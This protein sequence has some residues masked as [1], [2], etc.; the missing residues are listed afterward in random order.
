LR[1]AAMGSLTL[2]GLL[3]V[4]AC[5]LN[6]EESNGNFENTSASCNAEAKVLDQAKTL[7][8]LKSVAAERRISADT[9]EILSCLAYLESSY[10]TK[11]VSNPN[12]NGTIDRGLFQINS[13]HI[14]TTC[15]YDQADLLDPIKN[16]DCA[17]RVYS[18]SIKGLGAWSS[19]GKRNLRIKAIQDGE[20]SNDD[21]AFVSACLTNGASIQDLVALQTDWSLIAPPNPVTSD[22]PTPSRF[23][24]LRALPA[25]TEPQVST[26]QYFIDDQP[27]GLD[28][29]GTK[30]VLLAPSPATSAENNE[31]NT[32][33]VRPNG[34]LDNDLDTK[35]LRDG[36]KENGD[37]FSRT[38]KEEEEKKT[39]DYPVF[40]VEIPVGY[41]KRFEVRGF[42]GEGKQ[43]A[44]GIG[45]FDVV[46]DD[47]QPG[48]YIQQLGKGAYEVGVERP[49]EG[50]VCIDVEL[51]GWDGVF[52]NCD[53]LSSKSSPSEE[54][55]VHQ[56]TKTDIN[57]FIGLQFKLNQT[58]SART[59]TVTSYSSKDRETGMHQFEARQLQINLPNIDSFLQASG[60]PRP[61]AAC[62]DRPGKIDQV[63]EQRLAHPCVLQGFGDCLWCL[64]SCQSVKK[65]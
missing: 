35:T 8:L 36:I 59:F 29:Q 3:T 19:L 32:A 14:N 63:P 50:P 33:V 7:C 21:A 11:S 27:V 4:G 38:P 28:P 15:P 51:N 49:L 9:L 16:T 31:P 12:S 18:S 62:C 40:N 2:T 26:V 61:T 39:V 54:P 24:N 22:S 56:S 44:A 30:L 17:L 10:D 20:K 46:S 34:R 60:F 1:I 52:T 65:T 5:L 53:P 43:V 6:N 42:D 48:I 13:I 45:M 57:R 47:S 25:L 64:V 37:V 55:T 58:S 23:Y 41:R